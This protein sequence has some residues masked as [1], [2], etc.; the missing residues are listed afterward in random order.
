M[1]W[2]R[3]GLAVCLVATMAGCATRAPEPRSGTDGPGARPPPDLMQV[4]SAL[5]KI[6]PIREGGPNKPYA[7]LGQSYAPLRADALYHEDG[8][9]SWYGRKFHGRKTASG[10]V[11]NMYAMTAAHKT[12]P[13]PSYARVTNP[14]NGRSVVVRV[15]DRGPFVRGRIIDLSYTAALQLDTLHGVARVVVERITPE[16]IASGAWRGAAAAANGDDGPPEVPASAVLPAPALT[17]PPGASSDA[18]ASE[19]TRAPTAAGRGFWVQLG[20]YRERNGAMQLQQQASER[21]DGLGLLLA[22]FSDSALH[23]VQAGPF[24]TRDEAQRIAERVRQ[25]MLLTPLVL[26]RR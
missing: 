23:R 26:E 9:A 18:A 5:P 10:E 7:V 3:S 15:N 22:V 25:Q 8:L 13:I 19:P 11:Y 6:E 20:A 21:I 16:Q 1:S 14:A 2:R 4:P 24:A 17:P 12:L